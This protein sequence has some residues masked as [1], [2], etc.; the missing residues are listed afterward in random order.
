MGPTGAPGSTGAEGATGPTGAPGEP[1][2]NGP[3]GPT[4]PRG[5]GAGILTAWAENVPDPIYDPYP[6]QALDEDY[7]PCVLYDAGGFGG[8]A[9]PFKIWFWLGTPTTD[10]AS[11]QYAESNDGVNWTNVQTI[12]Q[13][14][15]LL[16]DG[17]EPGFFYH[18]YGPGCVLYNP[19]ATSTPG[20]PLSYPYA[21]Y[22]DIST[23]GFG[24]GS[25]QE[26]IGLAYSQDGLAWTRYGVVPVLIPAGAGAPAPAVAG[27]YGWDDSHHFRASV[28]AS[29]DSYQMYFSGSNQNIA[30]GLVYGHGIGHALSRDG[31][32]WARDWTNP[33]FYYNNGAAWRSGRTYAPCVL[34]RAD[35]GIWQMWFSGGVGATAGQSQAI[36][37][38]QGAF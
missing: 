18:F 14:A 22:Y 28:V 9:R 1:G 37:Y 27:W 8:G 5:I 24:P 29:G 32:T 38:A 4:G 34:H 36:G 10:A 30:D 31:T 35:L 17:A 25:S 11:G 15:P 2:A 23:E 7:F 12:T 13:A 20:R 19:A 26:S 21:M 6:S 33:I 16:V 3:T